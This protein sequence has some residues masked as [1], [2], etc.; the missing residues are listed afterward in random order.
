MERNER[1]SERGERERKEELGRQERGGGGS[2][3][4]I[5]RSWR[6]SSSPV[7]QAIHMILWDTE[8]TR[9]VPH[10]M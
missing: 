1:K 5:V 9:T 2:P 10:Y 7:S 4:E 6:L 8:S 3:I